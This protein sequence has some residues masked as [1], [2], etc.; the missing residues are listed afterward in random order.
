MC[1]RWGWDGA[2]SLRLLFA[3][4]VASGMNY[5]IGNR[6]LHAIKATLEEWHHWLE[7]GQHPFT[8]LTDHCNRENMQQAKHLN[9][10]QARWV[11]FFTC[12]HF[13]I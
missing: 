6:E 11:L 3:K 4:V 9:S 10:R 2:P 7:V 5:D 1:P 12:F 13:H 8:V